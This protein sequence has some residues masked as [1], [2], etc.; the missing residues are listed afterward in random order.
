MNIPRSFPINYSLKNIP[1]V[2]KFHYQKLLTAKTELLLSRMRWKLFWS[3]QE[4]QERNEFQSF[5]F[6]T[7]HTPPFMKELKYFEEEMVEMIKHVEMRNYSN[8]LQEKMR[9]DINKMKQIPEVIVQ[10]DKTSNM[11]LIKKE[12]Y[13]KYLTENISKE[14][15]KTEPSTLDKINVE[16][17][18]TAQNYNLDDRIEAI[19]KKSAFLTLKDHKSDFPARLNFRLI[20][21]CKSN[22]GKISKFILDRI[23]DE[24]KANT[25]LNQWKSTGEVLQWFRNLEGKSNLKWLK[26]DIESFYPSISMDLLN[27]AMTYAKGLSFITPEEED[28]IMHCRKTVLI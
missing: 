18:K 8:Q 16:A 10:A 9:E 11:Y 26:F 13:T 23:N 19:A 12:S 21:P 22:I 3:K 27:R 1:N 28:I 25:S 6:K 4:Q 17:A 24:V 15:K 20:N 14:Y 7:P 2:S 5:G